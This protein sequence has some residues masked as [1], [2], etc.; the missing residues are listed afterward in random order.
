MTDAV[1]CRQASCLGPDATALAQPTATSNPLRPSN[2]FCGRRSQAGHRASHRLSACDHGLSTR[3][4]IFSL[5]SAIPRAAMPARWLRTSGGRY[6]GRRPYHS[7]AAAP[8]HLGPPWKGGPIRIRPHQGAGQPSTI[9][10][11][12]SYA[13]FDPPCRS[14][15]PIGLR[16]T[17]SIPSA[18]QS[19]APNLKPT[20]R[21]PPRSDSAGSIP[22]LRLAA[23]VVLPC[24]GA[25]D[26]HRHGFSSKGVAQW[27]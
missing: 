27:A 8:G 11:R 21:P 23:G 13:L 24:G 22:L 6:N 9:Y 19:A 10:R 3:A 15:V 14:Q 17:A 5:Q 2:R 26:L 4:Q 18:Y 25:Y 20:F 16:A 12:R 1:L 7:F